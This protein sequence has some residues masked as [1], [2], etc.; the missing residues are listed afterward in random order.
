MGNASGR[1]TLKHKVHIHKRSMHKHHKHNHKGYMHSR[2]MHKKTRHHRRYRGGATPPKI[3]KTPK[4]GE[5]LAVSASMRRVKAQIEQER[6]EAIEAKLDKA[7]AKYRKNLSRGNSGQRSDEEKMMVKEKIASYRKNLKLEE[8]AKLAIQKA[9]EAEEERKKGK[10]SGYS[11][12]GF[13]RSALERYNP[14]APDAPKISRGS[15][16]KGWKSASSLE[17]LEE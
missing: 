12:E 13:S 11:N 5:R 15:R 17:T 8:E 16:G 9:K 3:R 14:D 4:E 6:Q 1:E 2:H 7:E 10:R